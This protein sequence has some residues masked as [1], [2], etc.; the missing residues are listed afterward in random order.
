MSNNHRPARFHSSAPF[1]FINVLQRLV[2]EV[3]IVQ[4]RAVPLLGQQRVVRPFLNDLPLITIQVPM[5]G[6]EIR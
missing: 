6:L 4:L 5:Y 3:E 2:T 1:G